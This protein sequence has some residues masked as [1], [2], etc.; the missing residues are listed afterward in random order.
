VTNVGRRPT[1]KPSDP[2]LAE[3]HLIGFEGDLYGRR[4]ELTFEHHLRSERRFEDVA[5][6]KRQIEADRNEAEKRL[7]GLAGATPTGQ[8]LR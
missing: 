8:T 2:V 7:A 4:I 3:A 1:F 6:L 5:A